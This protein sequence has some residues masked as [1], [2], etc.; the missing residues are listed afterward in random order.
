MDRKRTTISVVR[1]VP[2]QTRIM[3]KANFIGT[4]LDD[5]GLTRPASQRK[6]VFAGM[7]SVEGIPAM[8]GSVIF[9]SAYGPPEATDQQQFLNH[10]LWGRLTAARS[11]QVHAVD[12]DY[13]FVGIG[14]LAANRVLDDLEKHLGQA[15]KR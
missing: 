7:V 13:W 5:A 11:R 3:Q 6:N 1:F 15:V 14:I 9:Y 4:I 8:D 2:K 10:P 12:G